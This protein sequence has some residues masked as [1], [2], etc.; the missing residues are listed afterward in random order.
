MWWLLTIKPSRRRPKMSAGNDFMF[1]SSDS[2][3]I[4]CSRASVSSPEDV[5]WL[6]S[7]FCSSCFHY[8]SWYF[9]PSK[10]WWWFMCFCHVSMSYLTMSHHICFN[11][12]SMLQLTWLVGGLVAINFI[13]PLIL[14]IAHHPNWRS[15]SFF[16]GV[17]TN[18]QPDIM[19]CYIIPHC[20]IL[21]WYGIAILI[22]DMIIAIWQYPW[23]FLSC[24][25]SVHFSMSRATVVVD[26]RRVHTALG[27]VQ[28]H[29][30][31]SAQQLVRFH[32]SGG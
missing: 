13:F 16:R 2:Q 15:P 7:V 11:L 3:G 28:S 5:L 26:H 22:W 24:R 25:F 6:P 4:R 31:R 23:V 18:H 1:Q 29:A 27:R 30:P 9:V 12:F 19:I 20:P 8:V 10:V 17:Q 21:R 32:F 14:G